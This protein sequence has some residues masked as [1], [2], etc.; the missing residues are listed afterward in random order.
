MCT[1]KELQFSLSESEIQQAASEGWCFIQAADPESPIHGWEF[2][3][4]AD[5]DVFKD[6]PEAWA[7]VVKQGNEN[8]ELHRKA[9]QF[10]GRYCMNI[11]ELN[12]VFVVKPKLSDLPE[13]CTSC[14]TAPFLESS[15]LRGIYPDFTTTSRWFNDEVHGW[16]LH[17]ELRTPFPHLGYIDYSEEVATI[18]ID[19]LRCSACVAHSNKMHDELFKEIFS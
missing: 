16:D 17:L 5:T 8:S 7:Y 3:K 2:K 4:K 1:S 12:M 14:K 6:D 18:R 9:T 11:D 13:N 10:V 15:Q 19:S